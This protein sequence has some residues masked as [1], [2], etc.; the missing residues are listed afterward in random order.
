MSIYPV[1]EVYFLSETIPV[2]NRNHVIYDVNFY[3]DTIST[4]VTDSPA[5]VIRWLSE[6]NPDQAKIF[7]GLDIEWRPSFSRNFYNPV[8]TLQLCVSHRLGRTLDLR[9]E[10]ADRLGVPEL[11]NAGLRQLAGEVLGKDLYKPKRITL[12]RWDNQELT[13]EQ[14]RYACLD[15]FL[16]WQIGYNIIPGWEWACPF[17]ML[18]GVGLGGVGKCLYQRSRTSQTVKG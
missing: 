6:T 8:A 2:D 7:V 3:S 12:S 17:R 16:S 4:L 1:P 5:M 15:A 14:V 11:R 9:T 10:A 13:P 18:R